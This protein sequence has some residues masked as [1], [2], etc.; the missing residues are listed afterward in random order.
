MKLKR[1]ERERVERVRKKLERARAVH[2]NPVEVGVNDL[3][4]LLDL[5]DRLER[6][7]SRE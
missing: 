2:T 3:E 4:F 1:V 5:V 6:E 7:A